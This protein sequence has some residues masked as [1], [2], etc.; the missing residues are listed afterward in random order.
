MERT[1]LH[2]DLNNFYASVECLY[3]PEIR[4]K[5][6]VVGGDVKAR[7][8]IVLAKN[9]RA[10][11]RGIKTGMVLW[12]AKQL[13]P[14]MIV[15]PPNYRLYSHFSNTFRDLLR[16]Y[17]EQVEP[18]GLDECWCDVT[19]SLHLFGNGEQIANQIRDRIK[20]EL[21]VTASI[22]VS[23][24]KIFAKL[25][26]DMKKPDATTVISKEHYK[27]EIWSLPVADLLYVG[28]S[29]NNKLSRY[30]I[31][32]IGELANTNAEQ[33]HTILGK[34]GYVLHSFANGEDNTPV[35]NCLKE[36]T[37]KGIGNSKTAPR[38]LTCIDDVNIIMHV[39]C[40]SVTM[41]LRDNGLIGRT[42]QISLR[43]NELFTFERQ[44]KLNRASGLAYE[45]HAKAMELVKNNYTFYKPLRSV[46]VR[47]TDLSSAFENMQLSMFEDEEKRIKLSKVENAVFE[48]RERFGNQAVKK[49]IMLCDDM[50]KLNPKGDNFN[51]FVSYF[52]GSIV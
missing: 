26:S 45:I 37:I 39:L 11:A 2:V 28:R 19:N 43:N 32:T 50:G 44:G 14:D 31:T 7:S 46:G 3:R 27:K 51:P 6:V 42:V 52:N 25:G 15:I 18:F 47:V 8:G 17:T 24:N 1:I 21:G 13:C 12:Q 4:D 41:R 49:C 33:L 22:G 36:D 29:T 48:L 34:W 20:Y 16:N 38:D 40:E 35:S 10:K 23:F 5:F 9:N 30:G